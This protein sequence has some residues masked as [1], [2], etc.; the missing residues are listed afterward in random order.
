MIRKAAKKLLA[1][2][3]YGGPERLP[4]LMFVGISGA[5]QSRRRRS[6]SP[7]SGART[8]ASPPST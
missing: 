1:E 5:G 2:S 3:T 8:S 7:S 4:K 6:S